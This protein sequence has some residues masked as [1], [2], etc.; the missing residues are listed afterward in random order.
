MSQ[1]TNKSKYDVLL[2]KFLEND[3]LYEEYE[4]KEMERWLREA[5][6]SIRSQFQNHRDSAMEKSLTLSRDYV[7]LCLF[8]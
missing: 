3:S 2:N 7:C 8:R 5:E 6:I 1:S 4:K